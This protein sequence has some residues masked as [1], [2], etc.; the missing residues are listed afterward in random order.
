[1][2]GGV[3]LACEPLLHEDHIE[4]LDMLEQI[5][6][7]FILEACFKGNKLASYNITEPRDSDQTRNM[8]I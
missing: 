1:L 7:I 2:A 8:L 4:S 5:S 6:H 3:A